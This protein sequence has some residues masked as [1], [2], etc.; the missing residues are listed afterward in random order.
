MSHG[1]KMIYKKGPR[2]YE[3]SHGVKNKEK[4]TYREKNMTRRRHRKRQN[5]RPSR[6][7][8]PPLKWYNLRRAHNYPCN[9]H[10]REKHREPKPFQNLG[11]LLEKV[12][13]LH[14]LHGCSPSDVVREQM[15]EYG[16][17]DGDR[18]A[19]KEK[20]AKKEE[21]QCLLH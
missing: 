21:I 11:Y 15:G 5:N 8:Y 4:T 7:I 3:F 9:N 18:E 6:S 2:D 10:K 17:R 14:F 1:F 16:L 20:E 13:S 19:P 12:G